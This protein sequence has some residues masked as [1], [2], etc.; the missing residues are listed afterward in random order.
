MPSRA[1]GDEL[2]LYPSQHRVGSTDDTRPRAS[3]KRNPS[4]FVVHE[5]D[6]RGEKVQFEASD[7]ADQ[8]CPVKKEEHKHLSKESITQLAHLV[9]SEFLDE[10]GLEDFS[11]FY[12]ALASHAPRGT[13]EKS[14][15]VTSRVHLEKVGRTRFHCSIR[16]H[17]PLT[18]SETAQSNDGMPTFKIHPTTK[19]DIHRL[20]A[21]ERPAYTHFTLRKENIDTA[22]ALSVISRV[23]HVPPKAFTFAGAKDKHAITFQRVS[24]K[25]IAWSRIASVNNSSK[26]QVSHPTD[27]MV[28]LFLGDL[29]GNNFTIVLREVSHWGSHEDEKV[30]SIEVDGFI[31][32]YGPQRFGTSSCAT[33]TI[34]TAVVNGEFS[35]AL[36]MLLG[37]RAEFSAEFTAATD[38]L[39]FQDLQDNMADDLCAVTARY[40]SA[41]EACPRK[42]TVEKS[43]LGILAEQPRNYQAAWFRIPRNTR[44][45][46]THALQS[47]VW[48]EMVSAR[49]EAYGTCV[50][51]GDVVQCTGSPD[52]SAGEDS[53][54]RRPDASTS[55]FQIVTEENLHTFAM[56]DVVMPLPGSDTT[57]LYP[58]HGCGKEAY[59]AKLT[60]FRAERLF[61][62]VEEPG[63]YRAV[64]AKPSQMS[65]R[66]IPSETDS[67][68]LSVELSFS[69]R[70]GC[71]ATAL[72]REIVSVQ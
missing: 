38:G 60:A 29:T 24:A 5:V 68:L 55:D 41:Y 30:R 47:I 22:H 36:A 57:L 14:L 43:I 27:E 26:I 61:E 62:D 23:L 44:R 10:Q 45:L 52:K 53:N 56:L 32:Y 8:P 7:L 39:S 13:R 11:S 17:F 21:K 28:P 37:S 33:H 9:L 51:V 19:R 40:R 1:Y 48:N 4:D 50:V 3:I 42:L 49:L 63:G 64:M 16:E 34:G 71:Y 12:D 6:V 69:L 58:T 46:Y 54:G 70:K 72:L 15:L 2:L 20:E 35:V 67:E 18:S 31:N 59:R 66:V 65:H 25:G